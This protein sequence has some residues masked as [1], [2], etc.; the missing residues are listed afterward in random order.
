MRYA[1]VGLEQAGAILLC[2]F[3]GYQ[4]DQLMGWKGAWGLIAGAVL[5]TTF[6]MI[7]LFLLLK[8]KR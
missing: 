1:G 5:G 8:P 6:S 4:L 3:L 7:R 2:L